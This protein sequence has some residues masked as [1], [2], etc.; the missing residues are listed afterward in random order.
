M[1]QRRLP[2]I[3]A[4]NT[5]YT[6]AHGAEARL[7]AAERLRERIIAIGRGGFT[8]ADFDKAMRALRASGL[9]MPGMVVTKGSRRSE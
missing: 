5:A 9:S 8:T 7:E 6:R 3:S 2:S 1:V 4:L